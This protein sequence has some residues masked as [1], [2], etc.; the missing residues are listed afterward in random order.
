[1]NGTTLYFLIVQ[2]LSVRCGECHRED[3]VEF[4]FGYHNGSPTIG[5]MI[6]PRNG[7]ISTGRWNI[8]G[9]WGGGRGHDGLDHPFLETGTVKIM[10]TCFHRHH[11][12]SHEEFL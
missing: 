10:L 6:V 9:M 11:G 7:I 5:T 12:L 3:M 8:G 2:N 1:M 4:G